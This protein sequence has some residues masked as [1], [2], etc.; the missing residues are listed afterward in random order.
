MRKLTAANMVCG[1]CALL[2]LAGCASSPIVV[3]DSKVN[4]LSLRLGFNLGDD[5]SAPSAYKSG[6]AIEIGLAKVHGNGDQTL[7]AGQDPVR[8]GGVTFLPPQTI[9]TDC[10]FNYADLA[11][12]WRKFPNDSE[13]GFE[14]SGGIGRAALGM[15][16][17]SAT[18][19]AS[20][21]YINSGLHYGAALIWRARP[22]T[23]MQLRWTGFDSGMFVVSIDGVDSLGRYELLLT[24]ALGENAELRAGYAKWKINGSGLFDSSFRATFSGPE[25]E[26]GFNF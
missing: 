1:V 22:T 8:M 5:K 24:Q 7:A 17:T 14:L 20:H 2:S 18:Q 23:T 13:L 21:Q 19:S 25:I 16:L 4:T 26:L 9:H 6:S 3:E 10:N 12:R 11:Y 15:D